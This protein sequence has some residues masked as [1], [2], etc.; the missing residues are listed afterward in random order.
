LLNAEQQPFFNNLHFA[1]FSMGD[2]NYWSRAEEAH[3]F[4]KSGIDADAKL[5][6]LGAQQLVPCG[7]GDD[8]DE[9]GHETGLEKF[10]MQFWSA[11]M[12]LVTGEASMPVAVTSTKKKK[13]DVQVIK[14]DSNFLRGTIAEGL[15]DTST[16]ALAADDCQ[17]TKFHGIYQQDDRDIRNERKKAGL[18]PLYSFMIRV[19]VPGGVATPAQHLRISEL[20]DLYGN[21]DMKLTT[22]QAYQLHGIFKSDLKRTIQEINYTLMDT[23]AAC[24]DVNRNVMCSVNPHDSEVHKQALGLSQAISAHL[25]PQTS[26]Y[27]EIWLDKKR[28]STSP[29]VEPLYGKTYLPRKFKV[30]VAV[31]PHN[32]VDVFAHC[33]GFIAIVE[34]GEL[35]GYNVTAG[36]GMGMTHNNKATFPRLANVLGFCTQEQAVD[37]VE[38]IMLVQRD[39]GDRVNRKHARLKYTLEDH[40]AEWYRDEVERRLGFKLE[41]QRPY[42]FESSDDQFGWNQA[43]DGKWHYTLFVENGRVIDK[44]VEFSDGSKQMVSIKKGLDALM[45]VHKGEVRLTNNQNIMLSNIESADKP[46]LEQILKDFG[47]DNKQFAQPRKTAMACVALPTCTLALA[48][49]ERYLPKLVNKIEKIMTNCGIGE[50]SIKIRMTGCPNGCARPYLGEIGF[51][52]RAPG[53][54]NMYLGAGHAGERLN[55]LY[56]ESIGEA[57]ILEVLTPMI[58]AYSKDRET[59]EKFGDFT[60]RAGYVKANMSAPANTYRKESE[61]RAPANTFHE[62]TPLW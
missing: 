8:Q 35:V 56:K 14:D 25:S 61:D 57:Q 21:G 58:E 59:D 50:E 3:F 54:Y 53:L 22:R 26:A 37:V 2:R 24:G 7:I 45:A 1:V 46:G 15:V 30:A 44:E 6:E 27:H 4:C 52:G 19:R 55:K 38:K 47:F 29:D 12:Q 10:N 13:Q 23:L 39:Y 17:L 40:G 28:V 5:T 18:E 33:A 16:G 36:G 31:P 11:M 9:D 34:N 43:S 32:D 42:K 41:E 60:I 48:E 20:A 62:H 49:A 51:V